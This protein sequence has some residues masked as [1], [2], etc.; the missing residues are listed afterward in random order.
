[1]EVH[2]SLR[3][4]DSL[5]AGA[6]VR[7]NGHFTM[8]DY[9]GRVNDNPTT[10]QKKWR[11]CLV[12]RSSEWIDFLNGIGYDTHKLY[13]FTIILTT[14]IS[15]RA[16]NARICYDKYMCG[17]V[18]QIDIGTKTPGV[19]SSKYVMDKVYHEVS[20]W[21]LVQNLKT[22]EKYSSKEETKKVLRDVCRKFYPDVTPSKE[23]V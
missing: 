5:G 1:M 7:F 14:K 23:F 6:I 19:K 13:A 21:W 15:G 9:R 16:S 2:S 18:I 17:W 11:D 8:K 20:E 22:L 12:K 3:L 4:L 10:L